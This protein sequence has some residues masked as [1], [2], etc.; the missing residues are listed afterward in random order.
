M[1]HSNRTITLDTPLLVQF[2]HRVTFTR[3]VFL[4]TNPTLRSVLDSPTR[5]ATAEPATRRM[6]AFIDSNVLDAHPSLP[7]DIR[8]YMAVSANATQ[9][10]STS[11]CSFPELTLVE[12]VPG[13]EQAKQ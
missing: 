2:R 8:N 4:V 9:T 11:K 1:T 7:D 5:G 12:A 6:V 10:Q 13:G 3:G